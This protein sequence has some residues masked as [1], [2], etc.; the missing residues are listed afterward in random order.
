[1]AQLNPNIA[2]SPVETTPNAILRLKSSRL[3]AQEY[4]FLE[5]R[6][7]IVGGYDE[8]LPGNGLL[9]WHVDEAFWSIYGGPNNNKEC[10]TIPHCQ[11]ACAGPGL[12]YLVALEQAD[13]LDH[14]EF[15][16]NWGDAG[17]PFPGSA[18]RTVWRPWPVA[19]FNPDS[20]SWYDTN[21]Q[22]HSCIDLVSIACVPLGNCNLTVGQAQC[23]L[24]EADL[25]DAPASTNHNGLPMTTYVSNVQANFPTVWAG[26]VLGPRHHWSQVD[27]WLG[28][29]V[30]G[31]IDADLLP[32]QDPLTNIDPLANAANQDNFLYGPEDDGVA[33]PIPLVDCNGTGFSAQ[34]IVASPLMYAPIPRYFNVWF[35]WNGDGD[36]AD[37]LSCPGGWSAPEWAVRNQWAGFAPPSF[38]L[39]SSFL[40][41]IVVTKNMP[42]ETWMRVSIADMPAPAPEDGRGPVGG[43]DLGETEDYYLN[44][45]PTLTKWA[46]LTGDPSP[47]DVITYHIQY[48]SMGNVIAVGAAISDVLPIGLDYVSCNPPCT[49]TPATRTVWWGVALV[50]GQSPILDLVAQYMGTPSAVTNVANLIWGNTIWQSAYFSIGPIRRVYLPIVVRNW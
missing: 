34:V 50:P 42:Y 4:F 1:L 24:T 3:R 48:N 39:A 12:H 32:D 28:A 29:T 23:S 17:D 21:C 30:T 22:T 44:L 40:P 14:L 20:G 19:G 36:W 25:G 31:E 46:E 7:Q 18:N 9:I 10:T 43:Y 15:A 35:D 16:A 45:T 49:Y 38:W 41:R 26:S 37:T 5:N 6:Q 13:G 11:G 33:L 8:W 2:L 47:G 27:A